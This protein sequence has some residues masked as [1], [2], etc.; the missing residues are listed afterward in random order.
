[1][2]FFWKSLNSSGS[3]SFEVKIADA[4]NLDESRWNWIEDEN[5]GTKLDNGSKDGEE[6]IKE[7]DF[8]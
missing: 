4:G 2:I 6:W 7:D 8:S 5:L 3:I 1:M